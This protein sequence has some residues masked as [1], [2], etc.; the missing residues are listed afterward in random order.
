[1]QVESIAKALG[2]ESRR[3][4][5]ELLKDGELPAST[6]FEQFNYAAPTISR[7]LSVLKEAGIVNTRRNGVFIYYSLE[8]Q[9]LEV[10]YN[11]LAPLLG[12]AAEKP[13]ATPKERS[14]KPKVKVETNP[15]EKF[16]SEF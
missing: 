6:I 8:K 4:I 16:Q 14:S 13:K 9:A 15:F 2:D 10:I 11:W 12:I 3:K 5:V 7:H 1:M